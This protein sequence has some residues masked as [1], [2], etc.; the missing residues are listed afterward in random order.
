MNGSPKVAIIGAGLTGLLTAHGLKKAGFDV[1]LFEQETSLDARTRDWPLLLHWALPTVQTLLSDSALVNFSQAVCNPHLEYTPAVES[2]PCINGQTGEVMMR[3]NM[4]GARRVAR[5]RLRR[6]MAA[7]LASAGMI[8]WNKRLD[9]I[10]VG[11]GGVRLT[12]A[13]RTTAEADYV[14]GAD[15]ASSK[16]REWLFRGDEAARVKPSGLMCA[17]AVVR[18]GDAAKVEA[19][20][21]VH[22]VAAVTV[23]TTSNCG[24]SVMYADDPN[25]MSTW[26]IA[27]IK[28]W[29]R[30]TLPEPPAKR[31]PEALAYIKATSDDLI[32]PF[33]SQIQSTPESDGCFIDEM[34]TWVPVMWETHGGRVTLAGDAAHPML[35][36]RGQGFQ[37][38]VVDAERYVEALVSV[39]DGRAKAEEAVQVYT[40]DVVER[41][42]KAVTQSLREAELSMDLESVGKMIM[43]KQGHAKS[44]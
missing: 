35:V 8:R 2:M 33:R 4:P 28:V 19:V 1:V 23:G 16:V 6:V 29:R 3:S 40:A 7:D 39:R 9:S 42:A 43:A 11:G 24:V 21:K 26:A 13:D 12:F 18:H 36:Y 22:P 41:G 14:F 25:D 20:V 38:A 15:G 32:E 37:H 27:W 31:G 5:Q 30:S 44:A 34:R 10:D 17:T